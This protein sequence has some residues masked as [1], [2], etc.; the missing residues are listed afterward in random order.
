MEN[1]AALR[2]ERKRTV[3]PQRLANVLLHLPVDEIGDTQQ[4]WA[5]ASRNIEY[6]AN[7]VKAGK[8]YRPL[9]VRGAQVTLRKL[10]GGDIFECWR[11]RR[12]SKC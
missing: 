2:S 11:S 7:A 3:Q 6:T 12:E 4:Y 10:D 9:T 8:Y 5:R 1:G